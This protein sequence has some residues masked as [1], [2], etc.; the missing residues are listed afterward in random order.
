[1]RLIRSLVA[2]ALAVGLSGCGP[3]I[4]A[5]NAR[6]QK[7]YQKKVEVRGQI[8]RTQ[9]LPGEVLL[10]IADA[11]GARI[12]VHATAP[13]EGATGDWVLVKGLLVPEARVG[14][15]VLY[16]VIMADRVRRTRAPRLRN[17]M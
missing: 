7:Y 17:L 11:R 4:S 5:L 12:L 9:Q 10:E 6:P 2:C 13:T 16:D 14:D 3:S 1:M 8:M 15:Q